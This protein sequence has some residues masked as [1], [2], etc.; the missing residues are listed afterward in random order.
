[1]WISCRDV[2]RPTT[3]T[4][5]AVRSKPRTEEHIPSETRCADPQWN[6]LELVGAKARRLLDL[7]ASSGPR[8]IELEPVVGLV[9]RS[10]QRA[11]RYLWLRVPLW[12]R[13]ALHHGS[14]A[15]Q[16]Y[17]SGE[18]GLEQ[19]KR[20]STKPCCAF[21]RWTA[22]ESRGVFCF[23][24]ILD[25]PGVENCRNKCLCSAFMSMT[26]GGACTWS[27]W[28]NPQ[29]LWRLPHRQSFLENAVP[30]RNTRAI[31]QLS[32]IKTGHIHPSMFPVGTGFPAGSFSFQPMVQATQLTSAGGGVLPFCHF[33]G[34]RGCC[35]WTESSGR[36]CNHWPS[37]HLGT[38]P[39]N[40]RA[41]GLL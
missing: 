25:D 26:C 38:P 6:L 34:I 9:V 24:H 33:M 28:R 22:Y 37:A 40:K 16:R 11:P 39:K 21:W 15:Q 1:M 27:A 20:S 12:E 41:V 13:E 31:W 30:S 5:V 4:R 18:S 19:E 32:Y 17:E 7:T 2:R 10:G 23:N 14:A 8:P 3:R 36:D 35:I 29:N